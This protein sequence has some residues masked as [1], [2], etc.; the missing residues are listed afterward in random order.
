[1]LKFLLKARMA[2]TFIGGITLSAFTNLIT[3][4]GTLRWSP[5][6][7]GLL[8]AAGLLLLLISSWFQLRLGVLTSNA[9][10]ASRSLAN[11][12]DNI[13]QLGEERQYYRAFLFGFVTFVAGLALWI[14]FDMSS[15]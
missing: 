8:G 2:W 15:H 7:H 1:M 9:F 4:A 12:L 5:L 3:G 13:V 11:A 6:P 10:E 14:R